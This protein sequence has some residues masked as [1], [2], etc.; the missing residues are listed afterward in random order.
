[1]PLRLCCCADPVFYSTCYKL[2]TSGGT[3]FLGNTCGDACLL[4]KK[5]AGKSSQ[6]TGELPQWR[7]GNECVTCDT[8]LTNSDKSIN[9]VPA[10]AL[11]T[12]CTDCFAGSGSGAPPPATPAPQPSPPPSPPPP[13]PS[14]T[15]PAAG[16]WT[17]H[18]NKNCYPP[19][20]AVGLSSSLGRMVR[21]YAHFAAA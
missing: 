13:S 15:F 21:S 20:D 6:E 7:Y 12:V 3:R 19:R 10:W 1:M 4:G 8:M 11:G 9:F 17:T 14:P 18:S 16:Q 5:S 2:H